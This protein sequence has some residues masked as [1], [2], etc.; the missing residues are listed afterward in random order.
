[1]S[2]EKVHRK[3]GR[4][5]RPMS[6]D[7]LLNAA[8]DAF[9]ANGYKGTPLGLIAESL[10]VRKASL[11]HHVKNKEALYLESLGRILVGLGELVSEA[12]LGQ[13]TFVERLDRLGEL[14]VEFLASHPHAARLLYREMMDE[15]PFFTQGG[16]EQ[17]LT[18][19]EMTAAFFESGMTEGV[20]PKQDPKHLAMSI[21][22]MIFTWYTAANLSTPLSGTDAFSPEGVATRKE[23][24]KAHMRRLCGADV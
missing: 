13:G 2:T 8:T 20:V 10:G 9:A 4:P 24:V 11:F 1:M 14:V 16:R 7:E 3:A 17:V 15:G 6:R 23:V 12:N 21:V 18:T 5:S 22:G 19:L